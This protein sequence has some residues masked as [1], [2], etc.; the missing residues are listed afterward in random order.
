[1]TELQHDVEHVRASWL[2]IA[3]EWR[4]ALVAS[5][6]SDTLFVIQADGTLEFDRFGKR[7]FGSADTPFSVL[8]TTPKE[9]RAVSTP[10]YKKW[11]V[12]AGVAAVIGG[13]T[14]VWATSNRETDRVQ[15]VFGP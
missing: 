15:G 11:W 12:W 1:M 2:G 10:L 4:V 9:P 6:S 8:E 14:I 13:G 5:F 3:P 7:V